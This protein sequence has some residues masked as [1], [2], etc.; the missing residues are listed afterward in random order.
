[1]VKTIAEIVTTTAIL[2][3]FLISGT[4]EYIASMAI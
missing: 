4:D 1:V 2:T 3:G